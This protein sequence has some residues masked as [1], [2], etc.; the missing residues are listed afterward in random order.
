MLKNQ[1]PTKSEPK[2]KNPLKFADIRKNDVCN[3]RSI[4]LHEI[5]DVVSGSCFELML[6]MIKHN[7]YLRNVEQGPGQGILLV[8]LGVGSL[9]GS[10]PNPDPISDKKM[11]F[12]HTHFQSRPPN[13]IPVF[14]PHLENF[15][16]GIG[17]VTNITCMFLL[18]HAIIT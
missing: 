1:E 7:C 17:G 4:K 5:D 2:S 13:S 3:M 6:S 12:F 11:L 15:C 16:E 10:S 18:N 14:Q 9:C 8:I